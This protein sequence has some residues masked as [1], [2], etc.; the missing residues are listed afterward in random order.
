MQD[1]A[2]GRVSPRSP[3]IKDVQPVWG[4]ASEAMD[5]G[6]FNCE[7]E[8]FAPLALGEQVH[9]LKHFNLNVMDTVVV[10]PGEVEAYRIFGFTFDCKIARS[11]TL[12]EL[13]TTF[14]II[15]VVLKPF[16]KFPFGLSYILFFACETSN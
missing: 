3:L 9:E 1:K 10:W 15:E 6:L 5:P 13:L 16:C 2:T 7:P 12:C 8:S 11:S 4:C 14:N